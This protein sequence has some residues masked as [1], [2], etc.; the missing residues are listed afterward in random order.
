MDSMNRMIQWM[1]SRRMTG[2]GVTFGSGVQ[3]QQHE[4]YLIFKHLML[5]WQVLYKKWELAEICAYTRS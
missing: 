1:D 3:G 5:L 2:I 4:K